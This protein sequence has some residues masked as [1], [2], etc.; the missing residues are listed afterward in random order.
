[1][2]KPEVLR[3]VRNPERLAVLERLG[4]LDSPAEPAFDRLTRLASA[5]LDTPVALV[6]LV[7]ADRQFFK[8][9]VGLSEPWASAR[10]TPLTY[11]FC[12]HVVASGE[13]LVVVDAREH[14]VV[15]ENLAV[16]ELG[17]VAYAGM[18]LAMSTGHVLG[19]LCTIDG[20]KRQ[21][22]ERDLEILRDLA[23]AVVTEIEL[24]A[25]IV[26]RRQT[27]RELRAAK[28]QAEIASRFK[29]EFLTN[30]SHELR[31]P[32]N[33]VIGFA[34]VLAKNPSGQLGDQELTLL[35][36]IRSNGEHLLGLINGLLDL[37]KIEAGRFELDWSEVDLQPVIDEVLAHLEGQVGKKP[38]RLV[39]D[40]PEQ[41]GPIRADA[42]RLKQVLINLVGNAVKFTEEGGIT[43][44]LETASDGRPRSLSVIDTGIG[45]PA[46]RQRAVFE[47]F[48]QAD[49]TTGRRYG[50]TGLGLTISKSL[51]EQMGFDLRLSSR[52]GEG[53]TF[54]IDFDA[55][56]SN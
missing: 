2:M 18:P 28:Q 7:D 40:I 15:R 43:V 32:L 4:L 11:S 19:A 20:Q 44:R 25:E 13:P 34:N 48:Q 54:T 27:E 47:S 21:W 52:E 55:G 23:A 6:S 37:S 3:A 53:S 5:L 49:N 36:R 31:T 30:M 16:S 12:K 39:A 26:T 38:L 24:R 14:P 42:G 29:S 50:G 17:V 33:S 8:S 41:A 10:E 35:E 45:I 1:M 56:G 46:D 51:L 9:Q 22:S